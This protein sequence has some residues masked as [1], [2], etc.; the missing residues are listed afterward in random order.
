[1]LCLEIKHSSFS[2]L[3]N[4]DT[5]DRYATRKPGLHPCHTL[6]VWLLLLL[7]LLLLLLLPDL[8]LVVAC[9]S[10]QL[11]PVLRSDVSLQV[12]WPGKVLLAHLAAVPWK[13]DTTVVAQKYLRGVKR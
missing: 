3:L 7:G 12:L 8:L 2:G 4:W 1:M 5:L 13:I 10:H 9:P 6:F 11:C